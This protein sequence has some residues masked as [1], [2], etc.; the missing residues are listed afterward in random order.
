MLDAYLVRLGE[1]A[2][3]DGEDW[4]Y[5]VFTQTPS[6]GSGR[7][8]CVRI[9]GRAGR[10]CSVFD[11]SCPSFLATSAFSASWIRLM[12]VSLIGAFSSECSLSSTPIGSSTSATSLSSD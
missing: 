8:V 6:F 11:A 10:D 9:L 1:L 12:F 3:A 7:L 4:R 2:P 5:S